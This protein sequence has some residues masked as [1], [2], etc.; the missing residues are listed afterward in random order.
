MMF[1]ATQHLRVN[2]VHPKGTNY[3]I[4]FTRSTSNVLL[5]KN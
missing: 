3:I 4:S 1:S 5:N 2:F